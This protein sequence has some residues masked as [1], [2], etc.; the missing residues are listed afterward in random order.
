MP[1]DTDDEVPV[2]EVTDS[3]AVVAANR[4]LPSRSV[5]TLVGL[6]IL[7]ITFYGFQSLLEWSRPQWMRES[8]R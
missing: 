1:L 6:S 3:Q 4:V 8:T 2:G 5:Q 7:V